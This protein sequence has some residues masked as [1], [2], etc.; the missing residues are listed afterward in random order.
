MRPVLAQDNVGAI[1]E[2]RQHTL[3]RL[4]SLA[5]QLISRAFLHGQPDT[6]EVRAYAEEILEIAQQFSDMFPAGSGIGDT[7]ARPEIWHNSRDFN[8][9]IEKF[10]STASALVAAAVSGNMVATSGALSDLG[11]ACTACHRVYRGR[12]F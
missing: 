8:S 11:S 9:K 5:R 4:G 2:K 7:R 1:I 3:K 10:R 12:R 6:N